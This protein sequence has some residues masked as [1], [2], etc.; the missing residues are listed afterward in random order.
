MS[1]GSEHLDARLDRIEEQIQVVNQLASG[2]AR[3]LDRELATVV[4]R[5]EALDARI[6]RISAAVEAL[7]V[8]VKHTRNQIESAIMFARVGR[9]ML[10]IVAAA[11]A[12]VIGI[13]GWWAEVKAAVTKLIGPQ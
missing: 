5:R 9:I 3:T 11:G 4:I 10:T 13:A 12:T 2:T 1:A 8:D 6:E 7:S